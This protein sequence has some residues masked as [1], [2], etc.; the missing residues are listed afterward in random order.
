MLNAGQFRDRITIQTPSTT[1]NA[2]HQPDGWTDVVA[3]V[4]ANVQD[5]TGRQVYGLGRFADLATHVITMR[6]R[7]DMSGKM[8]IVWEGRILIIHGAPLNPDGVK[9]DMKL[10]CEE[11]NG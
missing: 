11:A 1:L 8:R 6:W 9:R 2:L 5:V 10:I 3:N 4:E 7:A